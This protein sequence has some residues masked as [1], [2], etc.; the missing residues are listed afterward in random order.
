MRKVKSIRLIAVLMALALVAVLAPGAAI[1]DSAAETLTFVHTNDVHGHIGIEPYVK[2]V[3]DSYKEKNGEKNVITASAGDVFGGGQAIAHLTKG[4]A[5]ADVMNAAG[6]DVMTMGN[7]DVLADCGQA[8]SFNKSGYTNFPILAGNLYSK[9]ND[10]TNDDAASFKEGDQPLPSYEIFY[11]ESG[12]KVGIF[13]VTCYM[14]DL[15]YYYTDGTIEAA[16]RCVDALNAEGCDIIVGLLH[17]GW[18]DDLE[19]V[20]T[21]DVNSYKVAMAVDGIDLII[22]GH[23]HSV[24][25]GGAGYQCDNESKTLIV[26]AGCLGTTIGVASLELDA[27]HNILS[28]SAKLLVGGEVTENYDPDPGVLAVVE[29]WEADFSKEYDAVVGH[30]DYLLNA[31]RASAS[32]DKLGIRLAE[33]NL[34]NL[35]TDAFLAGIANMDGIEDAD[36]VLFDGT[37]IRA[38]IAQGDIT[39]LDLMNVFANGGTL[40]VVEVTGAELVEMLGESVE[41]SSKG[42]ENMAF[43]QVAGLSFIYDAA[44]GSVVSVVMADGSKLDNGAVYR[45]AYAPRSIPEDADIAYD[46]YFELADAVQEYLNSEAYRPEYYAGPQGRITQIAAASRFAD[47][48]EDAWYYDAVRYVSSLGVFSGTS[49]TT[50]DPTKTMTRGMLVMTLYNYC[51]KPEATGAS[52]FG[53]VTADAYYAAAVAWAEENDIVGGVGDGLFGPNQDVSREQIVTILYRFYGEPAALDG[54]PALADFADGDKVSDWARDAMEW[55]LSAGIISGYPEGTLKPEGTARRAEV[56]QI[57]CGI[58]MA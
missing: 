42:V 4:Y 21:N 46:G 37:R 49:D 6:Y 28:K 19:S 2:A 36:V 9:G 18:V 34:G 11:T 56:A 40:C 16:Q 50:F 53:D 32:A 29:K 14:E 33:Q 27:N 12:A 38:S 26:Q 25:N 13:G 7:N 54:G 44:D 30:T 43:K 20:S 1:A 23:S 3:A 51:G 35:V 45:V 8:I 22:D 57:Y 41:Y 5:I 52:S 10:T 17:T 48:G 15:S 47:V 31:E 58:I 39:R 24:I 55:A